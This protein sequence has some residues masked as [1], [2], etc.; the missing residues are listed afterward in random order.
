MT[1]KGV[2]SHTWHTKIPV[3][4][5]QKI[6][7]KISLVISPEQLIMKTPIPLVISPEKL[8]PKIA[9]IVASWIFLKVP[10]IL[11]KVA[12]FQFFFMK[13]RLLLEKYI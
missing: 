4:G 10:E 6:T 3:T 7:G 13:C 9:K 2:F 12:N 1:Q 11:E 8:L 5:E